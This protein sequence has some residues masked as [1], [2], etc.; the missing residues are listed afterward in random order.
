MSAFTNLLITAFGIGTIEATLAND[1]GMAVFLPCFLTATYL[2]NEWSLFKVSLISALLT[3]GGGWI[4]Q[5]AMWD[6]NKFIWI[7]LG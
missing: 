5:V 1:I 7:V 4:R 6:D 3:F 2:Y